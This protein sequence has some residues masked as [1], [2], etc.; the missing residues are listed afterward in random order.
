[1]S[2]A[3]VNGRWEGRW[4]DVCMYICIVLVVSTRCQSLGLAEVVKGKW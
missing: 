1:M 2:L 4:F 3:D